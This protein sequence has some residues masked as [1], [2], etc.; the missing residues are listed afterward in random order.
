MSKVYNP[1]SNE[2]YDGEMMEVAKKNEEVIYNYLKENFNEVEDVSNNYEYQLLDIDFIVKDNEE[3]ITF[4]TKSDQHL[5]PKGN[6]LFEVERWY[7]NN[8]LRGYGW[9]WSSKSDF[10]IIR[11]SKTG[12]TLIFDFFILRKVIR[13]FYMAQKSEALKKERMI[14]SDNNKITRVLLIPLQYV[15]NKYQDKYNRKVKVINL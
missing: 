4:E 11:N 15:I 7:N 12:Y 8:Y 5:N 10:L 9:G 14:Y 6:L 1:N 13:D 3:T 2:S